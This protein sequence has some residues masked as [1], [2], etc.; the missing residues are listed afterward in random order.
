M[1]PF[2]KTLHNLQNIE[3][4]YESILNSKSSN[5]ELRSRNHGNGW[6]QN[7][8]KDELSSLRVENFPLPIVIKGKA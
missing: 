4:H 5:C 7:L 6:Q 3:V 8:E 1:T 2:N